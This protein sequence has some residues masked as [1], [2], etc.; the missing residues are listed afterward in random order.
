MALK[1][2]IK[3]F[4]NAVA[5]YSV[6]A[7]SSP[8][9]PHVGTRLTAYRAPKDSAEASAT[10]SSRDR[11][12]SGGARWSKCPGPDAIV[13][14]PRTISGAGRTPGSDAV[15]PSSRPR[16][17]P[18][19]SPRTRHIA[20]RK[21]C[22]A[23]IVHGD[24]C[25]FSAPAPR[26]RARNVIPNAFTKHAAASALVRASNAPAI[27]K[28]NRARA[29]DERWNPNRKA[30][31]RIHSLTKP[32]RSGRPEMAAAPTRKKSAVHGIR[33]TSPPI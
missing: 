23:S 33:L 11:A 12:T 14:N 20:A 21:A 17:Q 27:G 28:R 19:A 8:P 6:R 31:K 18:G 29:S 2:I 4:E 5:V 22:G 13:K 10:A 24:S 1:I 3:G 32:L 15:T 26:G 7:E 9:Q 30:W 25:A 16:T